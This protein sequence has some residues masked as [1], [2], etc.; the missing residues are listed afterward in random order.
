MHCQFSLIFLP[1]RLRLQRRNGKAAP[2]GQP[3]H[4][5]LV[6]ALKPGQ[7]P[8]FT[9]DSFDCIKISDS[10][11]SRPIVPVLICQRR[12]HF[13]IAQEHDA[14][15]AVTIDVSHEAGDI[16][17][18]LARRAQTAFLVGLVPGT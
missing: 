2:H 5:I 3:S 7:H 8:G 1:F 14:I 6:S 12:R 16:S 18:Q 9:P 11:W 10:I 4:F 15:P 17:C 13:S